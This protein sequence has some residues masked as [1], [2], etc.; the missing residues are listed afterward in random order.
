MGY[1]S[2]FIRSSAAVQKHLG[3]YLFSL[4]HMAWER[5]YYLLQDPPICSILCSPFLATGF[6]PLTFHPVLHGKSQT[7]ASK[8]V[9]HHV[10]GVRD[11]MEEG[12]HQ[13]AQTQRT[14]DGQI[15]G[16]QAWERGQELEHVSLSIKFSS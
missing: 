1:V 12:G 16:E 6:S 4:D 11:G 10:V 3:F 13:R 14:E 7:E 9:E 8:V 15:E 2:C 5:G